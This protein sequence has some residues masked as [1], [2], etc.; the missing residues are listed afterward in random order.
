VDI[1][2]R[3]GEW[4]QQ[5]LTLARS[6]VALDRIGQHEL[7][8]EVLGA[9]EHHA[10]LDVPPVVPSVRDVAIRTRAALAERFGVHRFDELRQAG[11]AVSLPV[12]VDRTRR[13]LLGV[14]A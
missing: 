6:V 8:A 1:W 12:L 4:S 9:F 11:I 3:S 13:S 5:W 10:A 14:G 7:A 2:Y